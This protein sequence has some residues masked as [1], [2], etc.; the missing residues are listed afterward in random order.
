M[1]ESNDFDSHETIFQRPIDRAR[2]FQPGDT[3]TMSKLM[4]LPEWDLTRIDRNLKAGRMELQ[5]RSNEQVVLF[6]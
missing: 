6:K 3:I 5:R 1:Y 2:V 4:D